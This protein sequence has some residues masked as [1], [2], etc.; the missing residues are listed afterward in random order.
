VALKSSAATP[1][2]AAAAIAAAAAAPVIGSSPTERRVRL[3]R[4]QLRAEGEVHLIGTVRPADFPAPPVRQCYNLV[5][6]N[7]VTDKEGDSFSS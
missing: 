5:A 7:L 3:K 2:T 6:A 1:T 4:D